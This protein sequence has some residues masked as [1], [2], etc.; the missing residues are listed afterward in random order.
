M[1]E[2]VDHPVTVDALLEQVKSWGL[3][4]V[5]VAGQDNTG[6]VFWASSAEEDEVTLWLLQRALWSLMNDE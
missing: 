3:G 4:N 2:V 5:V 6:E 1:G